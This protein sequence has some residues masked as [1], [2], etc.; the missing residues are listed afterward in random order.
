VFYLTHTDTG[1]RCSEL[2]DNTIHTTLS[3]Q[4]NTEKP[5]QE[6]QP[7]IAKN[8]QNISGQRDLMDDAIFE[9]IRQKTLVIQRSPISAREATLNIVGQQKG[10]RT[11]P[12]RVAI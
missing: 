11:K 2:L 9:K 4:N 7:T 8:I 1:A 6:P 10:K 3:I 5:E 12:I